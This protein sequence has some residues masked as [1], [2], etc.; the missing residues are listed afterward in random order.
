MDNPVKPIKSVDK[1]PIFHLPVFHDSL[2]DIGSMRIHLE[3]GFIYI[4]KQIF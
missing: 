2:D 4:P 3:L 1:S